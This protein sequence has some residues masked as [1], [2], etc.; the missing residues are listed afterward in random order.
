MGGV[1]GILALLT[2]ETDEALLE[3]K[4]ANLPHLDAV[5]KDILYWLSETNKSDNGC[6]DRVQQNEKRKLS[7]YIESASGYRS[8]PDRGHGVKTVCPALRNIYISR[9]EVRLPSLARYVLL[10]DSS[11][12]CTAFQNKNKIRGRIFFLPIL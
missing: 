12:R 6:T 7:S 2:E 4:P 9:H 3:R 1:P 5:R 11:S 8:I 10:K